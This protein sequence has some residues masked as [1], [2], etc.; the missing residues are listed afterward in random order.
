VQASPCYMTILLHALPSDWLC[1]TRNYWLPSRGPISSCWPSLPF[2]TASVG[3]PE[4][5]VSES[6]QPVLKACPPPWMAV[7]PQRT[8]TCMGL[9]VRASLSIPW[10]PPFGPCGDS[11]KRVSMQKF[12]DST[13]LDFVNRLDISEYNRLYVSAIR[14]SPES[15]CMLSSSPLI[16]NSAL[17]C[18]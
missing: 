7:P 18:L 12:I 6:R 16:Y 10:V 11:P 3:P 4:S 14:N 2:S 13:G 8:S 15:T 5:A 9:Q 17:H 1:Y